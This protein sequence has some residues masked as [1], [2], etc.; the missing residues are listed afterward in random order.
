[1]RVGARG[2]DV[3]KSVSCLRLRIN[4]TESRRALYTERKKKSSEKCPA[5]SILIQLEAIYGMPPQRIPGLFG[6][7][8]FFLS[9]GHFF[10]RINKINRIN[11]E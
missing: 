5:Y 4:K 10:D 1:M 8:P 6:R 9:K 3:P 11:F 2:Q 7:C